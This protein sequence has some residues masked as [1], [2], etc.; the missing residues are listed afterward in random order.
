MKIFISI[1]FVLWLNIIYL[2]RNI[3]NADKSNNK[4][5]N[6]TDNMNS[7]SDSINKCDT[8][9]SECVHQIYNEE[10][11]NKYDKIHEYIHQ[12]DKF[13]KDIIKYRN[14]ISDMNQEM[15]VLKD[16]VLL[17]LISL[18]FFVFLSISFLFICLSI[19]YFRNY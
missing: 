1:F 3:V 17:S 14:I 4:I 13:K 5:S 15:S 2:Y 8:C 7:C 6:N 12:N 18:S 9:T 10:L 19:I 16:D 11:I